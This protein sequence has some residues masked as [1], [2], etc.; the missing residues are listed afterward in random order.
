[1]DRYGCLNYASVCAKRMLLDSHEFV[2]ILNSVAEKVSENMRPPFP[3]VRVLY[4]NLM[5]LRAEKD[6]FLC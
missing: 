1:M 5:Q 6:G 4:L 2:S 3:V